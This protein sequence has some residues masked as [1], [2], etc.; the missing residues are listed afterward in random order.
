MKS[1][2]LL[3]KQGSVDSQMVATVSYKVFEKNTKDLTSDFK[4]QKNTSIDYN[5]QKKLKMLMNFK[6]L[7]ISAKY[8][9]GQKAINT[10]KRL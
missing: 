7:E 5:R 2:K 4:R 6:V 3:H 1:T 8:Y 9:K 10:S